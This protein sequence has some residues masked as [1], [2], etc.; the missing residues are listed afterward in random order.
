MENLARCKDVNL[1]RCKEKD[2]QELIKRAEE[3]NIFEEQPGR[4]YNHFCNFKR[5][6][7]EELDPSKLYNW[8]N[9]HKEKM[10]KGIRAR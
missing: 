10:N 8:I 4:S 6:N 5:D 2:L 3:M 9:D 1:A 7:L